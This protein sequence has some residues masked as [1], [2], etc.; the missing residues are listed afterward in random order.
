MR[1]TAADYDGV[2]D[3]HPEIHGNV[4]FIITGNA[5]ESYD[6]VMEQADNIPVYFN[7][8]KEELDDIISHKANVINKTNAQKFYED[9]EIQVNTLKILC[10]NC[11][12]ILVKEGE[13]SI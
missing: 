13:T 9:Q 6:H 5:W 3:S 7:P 10:P 4:Q 1:P 12:I 2:W 11:K 8:G